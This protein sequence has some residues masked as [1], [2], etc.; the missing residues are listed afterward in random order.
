MSTLLSSCINTIQNYNEEILQIDTDKKVIT[1]KRGINIREL[2]REVTSAMEYIQE[3]YG[4]IV[5]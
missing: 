5:E 1:I 2:P 3:R 4:Y